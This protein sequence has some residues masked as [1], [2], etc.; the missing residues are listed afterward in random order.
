MRFSIGSMVVSLLVFAPPAHADPPSP[1]EPEPIDQSLRESAPRVR[2]GIAGGW[3]FGA[4]E[5]S[6]STRETSSNVGGVADIGV[7]FGDP[8]AA[9]VH[10]EVGPS[11]VHA[12]AYAI[13]EW[14]PLQWLSLGTGIGVD[15]IKNDQQYVVSPNSTVLVPAGTW[16]G[17]SIPIIA[18][19]NIGGRPAWLV[20]RSVFRIELEAAT[21]IDETLLSGYHFAVALG[22]TRM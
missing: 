1:E 19:L 11:L 15:W 21:G 20:R 3:L 12:A 17:V 7:Q 5:S 22:W 4:G 10:G 13:G 14:A 6:K 18:A 8:Y 2:F 16:T 9:Y